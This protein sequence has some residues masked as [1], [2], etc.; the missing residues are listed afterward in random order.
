MVG[1]SQKNRD[2][3]TNK[4]NEIRNGNA[5]VGTSR[6]ASLHAH[7]GVEQSRRDDMEGIAY[8]LIWL[9]KG[10]LPWWNEPGDD[11]DQ[12]QR[13]IYAKKRDISPSELCEGIPRE[14][15]EFLRDVQAL[16]YDQEP[17]YSRYQ[18]R[19]RHLFEARQ[20]VFDYRYDWCL[21][22]KPFVMSV[23][24]GITWE[25]AANESTNVCRSRGV[26]GTDGTMATMNLRLRRMVDQVNLSK[27]KVVVDI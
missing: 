2:L 5:F 17:E 11:D 16:G 10:T 27:P 25:H 12:V 23:S 8:T 3:T 13:N 26:R 21:N 4:H 9:L 7:E 1:S 6:F 22:Q 14:F 20:Y 19:F 24:T 18:R 15:E